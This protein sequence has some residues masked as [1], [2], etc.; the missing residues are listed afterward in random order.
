M[1][2][3]MKEKHSIEPT[4]STD[5]AASSSQKHYEIV[6]L[7][8]DLSH[9]KRN[10][11][12]NKVEY[13]GPADLYKCGIGECEN[14]YKNRTE[15]K[16]HLNKHHEAD[17]DFECRHCKELIEEWQV[18]DVLEHI[19]LHGS[20]QY[21]CG[22][23]QKHSSDRDVMVML[24]HMIECHPNTR[25]DDCQYKLNY[26]RRE[27]TTKK[28]D[29][30]AEHRFVMKCRTCDIRF[31]SVADANEHAVRV[32][33][34]RNIRMS[35]LDLIKESRPGP[36]T[37]CRLRETY[38]I[39]T[40]YFY[41]AQP[42][43]KERFKMRDEI[44][45]HAHDSHPM[46]PLAIELKETWKLPVD[47]LKDRKKP[48][49]NVPIDQNL[50]YVCQYCYKS[51]P[52]QAT[53]CDTLAEVYDHW[54]SAHGDNSTE[55][56][57]RFY[58]TELLSCGYCSL[59]STVQGLLKHHEAKHSTKPNQLQPD[60][61]QNGWKAVKNTL[62]PKAFSLE[63]LDFLKRHNI[64]GRSKHKCI[65]CDGIFETKHAFEAHHRSAHNGLEAIFECVDHTDI[66]YCIARCCG[67]RIDGADYIRHLRDSPHGYT[68]VHCK[69]ARKSV[70]K[71]VKHR[72]ENHEPGQ[73]PDM[74]YMA[75]MQS[76]FWSTEFVFANGFVANKYQL[77]HSKYFDW[78]HFETFIGNRLKKERVQ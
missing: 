21:Q 41:C 4:S 55:T 15:L 63:L 32:H 45:A 6:V 24:E 1:E 27:T 75:H 16:D 31:E 13:V 14:K 67:Q 23:C 78:T 59:M 5:T 35:L 10:S 37:A 74:L 19:C 9:L 39:T 34:F 11:L 51:S 77:Q 17:G 70:Y 20:D 73:S 62:Y 49:I 71:M 26:N 65:E 44:L 54:V 28:D 30:F 43:C 42:N 61:C 53:H 38:F 60:G 68:C 66:D 3:H 50:L 46:R 2:Q 48:T 69:T 12:F 29:I 76:T 25:F 22:V 64:D 8:P 47:S 36:I 72:V 57:F 18:D 56:P 40:Q 7:V 52:E 58:A 33:R